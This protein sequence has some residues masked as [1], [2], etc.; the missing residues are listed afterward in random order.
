M[1]L[2]K[3]T[4]KIIDKIINKIFILILKF[5]FDNKLFV[6]NFIIF[7]LKENKRA[8]NTAYTIQ[9]LFTLSPALR[10]ILC[11]LKINYFMNTFF[12]APLTLIDG[13]L[14]LAVL[15]NT[16]TSSKSLLTAEP[17]LYIAPV[18]LFLNPANV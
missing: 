17:K 13:F 4:T 2:E 12:L 3:I 8:K 11:Y 1:Y 5:I 16:A 7:F 6:F 9:Y 15:L 14:G 18:A 10:L